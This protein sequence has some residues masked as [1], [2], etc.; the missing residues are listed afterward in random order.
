MLNA[1]VP[2]LNEY[3]SCTSTIQCLGDMSCTNSLCQCGLYQY[4]DYTSLTCKSQTLYNTACT[5]NNTCRADLGLFC[6][7]SLCICDSK[8][9]FWLP[10]LGTT[11]SCSNFLTYSA[12]GCY[13]N[14]HCKNS[15]ICNLNIASNTCNCPTTSANSM[16][17][18]TR[19]YANEYY[20]N[21]TQ[22]ICV[23]ASSYGQYC[24]ADYMCQTIT[25]NLTC[26]TATKQCECKNGIFINGVCKFCGS[27]FTLVSTTCYISLSSCNAFASISPAIASTECGNNYPGSTI[28]VFTNPSEL[29]AIASII[30]NS[31]IG[32]QEIG[33]TW[34]ISDGTTTFGI[35]DSTYP[36]WCAGEPNGG[37]QCAVTSIGG[38]ITNENCNSKFSCLCMKPF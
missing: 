11:G 32:A 31:W 9:Q 18:C 23:T 21:S 4:F 19:T 16:C 14:S 5:A 22:Q 2:K 15:L 30:P 10:T 8:T 33:T 3:V 29:M 20:W 34:T 28:A 13:S 37:P 26:N 6:S 27:G 35:F 38:C 24:T 36:A 12:T 7:N 1:C 25:L 17:D